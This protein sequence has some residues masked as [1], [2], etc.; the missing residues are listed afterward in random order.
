MSK[1]EF[2]DDVSFNGACFPP[3]TKFRDITFK[4][5][6]N[7]VGGEINKLINTQNEKSL[8]H[9]KTLAPNVF[10]EITFL[11]CKFEGEVNFSNRI[12]KNTCIFGV[13]SNESLIISKTT[14]AKAPKFHNCE[15]HQ[16]T[17]FDGAEF[18]EAT[19]NEESARAYRTLKLAFNKMQAVR[20][21]Q[22]F[23]K[24][25][26][27]EEAKASSGLYKFL[28]HSYY[29]LSNFGFS[30]SK[31][32]WWCLFSIIFFFFSYSIALHFAHC[33][34]GLDCHI[35][36]NWL[37]FNTIVLKFSLINALPLPGIEKIVDLKDCNLY[38]SSGPIG[39]VITGLIFI[40]KLFSLVLLFLIGLALK[41]L[42]KFK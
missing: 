2:A 27:A 19:G 38:A 23:F 4:K 24:L 5:G 22:R 32:L 37:S 11:G 25:E 20:E 16:D 31:P 18:P 30:V 41:N 12:F 3:R 1:I 39:W 8:V 28:Y 17:S 10:Q 14:F 7:F 29:A 13:S 36:T 21:E 42:F 34:S 35:R 15:L 26:L 40:Q 6:A 9:D 33:N